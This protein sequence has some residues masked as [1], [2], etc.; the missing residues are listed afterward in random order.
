[1][2]VE[3]YLSLLDFFLA[4]DRNALLHE[5]N[6]HNH[7][8]RVMWML[9]KEIVPRRSSWC[10]PDWFHSE[11]FHFLFLV[12]LSASLWLAAHWRMRRYA[13]QM[14]LRFDERL[15]E[16]TRL[17]RDLH[18]TLLQTIQASKIVADS[19]LDPGTDQTKMRKAL[20]TLSDWLGQASEEERAAL[21][22]LRISPV[23][24][25]DLAANLDRVLFECRIGQCLET[26]LLVS[27]VPLTLQPVL[28]DEVF[29][30]GYEAIR[31]ACVHSKGNRLLGELEFRR[32]LTLKIIDNGTGVDSGILKHGKPGPFGLVGMR[33]RA[34]RI[35]ARLSI[36]SAGTG[37]VVSLVVPKKV[38]YRAA[39]RP[40]FPIA[41]N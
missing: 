38:I 7:A 27:G 4:T 32:N 13:D 12:I 19:A 34:D 23:E 5:G 8:M 39:F 40:A 2:I 18:D 41:S 24:T 26:E 14:K 36:T 17:A 29:R 21:E 33:E 6:S 11:S 28:N 16:R 37:T 35:G 25:R 30:I 20:S 22:S 1:M 15:Q 3:S 31:N 9:S 10:F